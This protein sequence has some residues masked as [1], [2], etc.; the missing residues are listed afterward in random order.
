M[1]KRAI[2]ICV[3][4]VL[5][6]AIGYG[7]FLSQKTTRLSTASPTPTNAQALTSDK[8]T[9]IKTEEVDYFQGIKGYYTAPTEPGNYP[10]VVMIHEWWGLTDQI[11]DMAEQLAK[12]GYQVL[13]VDLFKGSV[14][15][16]P[17][18]A[19]SQTSS[20]NQEEALDNLKTAVTFLRGK[21]AAKIASLGW[22]FGGGQSLQLSLSGQQLDGT[23]I[24]YGNLVT[25]RPKLQKLKGP[26]LGI[27]G[28]K[29]TSIPSAKVQEFETALNDLNIKNSITIYPGVG[30]AFA[31]PTGQSYAPVETKDAW[32]KTLL[33]LEQN[34]KEKPS[35]EAS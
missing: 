21:N 27:F 1:S 2:T 35:P 7:L 24:Y 29:D 33:F 5:V 18:Q 22:C 30:H 26:V 34:L 8:T 25:D 31:N 32:T 16:T 28:D 9:E 23:I 3:I 11:K 15:Q 19:R 12:E 4:G 6:A 10:G 17:E 14:A 13:A 20:L